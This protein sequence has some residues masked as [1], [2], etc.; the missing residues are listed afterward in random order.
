MCAG[1][2]CAGAGA[3]VQ[4]FPHALNEKKKEPSKC[5]ISA[6]SDNDN[7]RHFI[8][9]SAPRKERVNC[10]TFSKPNGPLLSRI[11]RGSEILALVLLRPRT[12]QTNTHHTGLL[13]VPVVMHPRY[14]RQGIFLHREIISSRTTRRLGVVAEAGSVTLSVIH[15]LYIISALAKNRPHGNSTS[16]WLSMGACF[17]RLQSWTIHSFIRLGRIRRTHSRYMIGKTRLRVLD[18]GG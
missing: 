18:K 3:G 16:G 10:N 2:V 1:V 13:H 4:D 14:S 5:H 12:V 17:F 9:L 6:A 8:L 15:V 7:G 11:L